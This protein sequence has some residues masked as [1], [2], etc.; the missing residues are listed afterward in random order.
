MTIQEELIIK[1]SISEKIKIIDNKIQH[2]KDQYD[3]DRQTAKTSALSSR[4]ISI[5]GF[6]NSKDVLPEKGLLEKVA[7][8]KRFEYSLLGKDLK[9]QTSVAEKR[10][11]RLNK[12]LNHDEKEELV[13][14][15][16]EKTET[17]D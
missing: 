14:I 2:N 8:L 7:A 4:N 9:T 17:T 6:L 15:K 10:Y 16:K 3:L 1:M 12:L 11:Q 5:Y 13:T